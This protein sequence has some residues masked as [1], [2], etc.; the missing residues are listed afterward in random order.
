M[1]I[2][3]I[4]QF[5]E[6]CSNGLDCHISNGIFSSSKHCTYDPEYGYSVLHLVDGTETLSQDEIAL[7]SDTSIVEAI[8]NGCL[9]TD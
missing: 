8:N 6:L 1:K 2:T 5:R 3:S 4:E 7:A 9:F